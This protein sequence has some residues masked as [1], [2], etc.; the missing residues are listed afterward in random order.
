MRIVTTIAA[1]ALAAGAVAGV[2]A[3]AF[4]DPAY[5]PSTPSP[6]VTEVVPAQ[7]TTPAAAVLGTRVTAPQSAEA[8]RSAEVAVLGVKVAAL[9]RTGGELLT[10]SVVGGVLIAGGAGAVVAAR[11]RP[12]SSH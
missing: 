2:S 9:P 10:W 6:T 11:R 7:T 3:P 4:A 1:A 5:P 12:D 8:A